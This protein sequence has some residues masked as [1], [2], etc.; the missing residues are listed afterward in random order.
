[1]SDYF[2]IQRDHIKGSCY[3]QI[4]WDLI[5][6]HDKQAQINHGGQTLARLKERGGLSPCEAIAVIEDRK[7]EQ[8]KYE[9]S[10]AR[11]KQLVEEF[12]SKQTCP[13]CAEKDAEIAQL[14]ASI[15]IAHDCENNERNLNRETQI[16]S[17]ELKAKLETSDKENSILRTLIA[18]VGKSCHYCGLEDISQCMRGFPGCALADDIL[19]GEEEAFK[20]A[21]A[22]R[23]K[24]RI[25]LETARSALEWCSQFFLDGERVKEALKQI[26]ES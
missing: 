15:Q 19:C 10:A 17:D 26:G 5:A 21:V 25:K 16:R 4:P 22:D 24:L 8:I 11:L 3:N 18:K 12:E 1:M 23:D 9:D 13:K 7:W 2:P 20:D 6:P 14:K